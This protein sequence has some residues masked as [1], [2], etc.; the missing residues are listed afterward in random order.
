MERKIKK[1]LHIFSSYGGG[2]SSLILNLIEKGSED[3]VFDT[4][5]FSYKNGKD[6]IERLEK[7]GTECLLM[8]R[9]RKKGMIKF[10]NELQ[11]IFS[12]KK[13]DAVHCHI[14]GWRV[15]PFYSI[16]KKNG[17][18]TFIIHAHTTKA[19]S[20]IDRIPL[21][22][23]INQ[24]CNY[25]WATEYMTCSDMAAD[26]IFGEKYTEKKK[27]IFIPNSINKELFE[28]EMN[29]SEISEYKKKLKI[30][31]K[32]RIILHIG[33]FDKQK[34]H[35]FILKI[36]SNILM[37]SNKYIFLFVGD[38]KLRPII[39]KKVMKKG[40]LD[41]VR[42]LGRRDDIAQ[43]I[44][45][46]DCVILP[47]LY[48]GLPTVAIES[49]AAGRQMI[50]S[51]TITKQCDMH[52][53]LLKFLPINSAAEWAKTIEKLTLEKK[54]ATECIDAIEK[55][56]FTSRSASQLYCKELNQIIN[57]N[58]TSPANLEK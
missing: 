44:Q 48:E 56:H 51:N 30:C 33:R 14:S 46:S 12:R 31:D 18:T 32:K 57:G 34:N 25:N 55:N 45:L 58:S 20:R 23:K 22:H 19:D 3:Y 39:E 17:V 4:L 26:Y 36:I 10:L 6:F 53:G 37:K 11:Y 5:A 52:L 15:W 16:A 43:I 2:I 49:Q 8:S 27:P 24:W 38:G 13:Y 28:N 42:F 21:I 40:M 35:K 41:N 29:Q 47:S 1:V 50:L 54:T 7:N 9:P